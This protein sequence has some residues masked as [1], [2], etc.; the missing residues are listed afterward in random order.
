MGGPAERQRLNG[1]HLASSIHWAGLGEGWGV[2]GANIEEGEGE[3]S[4]V[5]VHADT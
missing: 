2:I 3:K 1:R 5:F 4:V